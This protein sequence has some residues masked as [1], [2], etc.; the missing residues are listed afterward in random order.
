MATRPV[1]RKSTARPGNWRNKL[2][3]AAAVSLV[4]ATALTAGRARAY[5]GAARDTLGMGGGFPRPEIIQRQRANLEGRQEDAKEWDRVMKT[6]ESYRPPAARNPTNPKDLEFMQAVE[7]LPRNRVLTESEKEDFR[8]IHGAEAQ[9]KAMRKLGVQR[10][11]VRVGR[12][13][14][15]D[16]TSEARRKAHEAL[17]EELERIKTEKVDDAIRKKYPNVFQLLLRMKADT[18]KA[19]PDTTT[20]KGSETRDPSQLKGKRR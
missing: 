12:E 20:T 7:Q 10:D 13:I 16:P 8:G 1:A 5:T 17:M 19:E 3:R 2:T 6:G 18:S 15:R 14:D 11:T 4:A 9:E